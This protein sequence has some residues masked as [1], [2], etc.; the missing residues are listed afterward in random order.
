[1][2]VRDRGRVRLR[3]SRA[4]LCV[5]SGSSKS[6]KPIDEQLQVQPRRPAGFVDSQRFFQSLPCRIKLAVNRIKC[7]QIIGNQGPQSRVRSARTKLGIEPTCLV[8][9][10]VR[11]EMAGAAVRFGKPRRAHGGQGAARTAPRLRFST[12][13]RHG[14]YQLS[15]VCERTIEI[16]KPASGEQGRGIA[17]QRVAQGRDGQRG[18]VEFFRRDAVQACDQRLGRQ[19]GAIAKRS[20]DNQ[21]GEDRAASDSGPAPIGLKLG[22]NNPRPLDPQ[23]KDQKWPAPG[24]PACP[25]TSGD[26]SAPELRGDMKWSISVSEYL[27]ICREPG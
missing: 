18:A 1:M 15:G 20:A 6:R 17:F 2:S 4:C 21:L 10:P 25:V 12:T 14:D 3:P 19:S 9:L 5:T 11:G 26:S 8:M 16:E 13:L 22:R 24:A 27:P 7:G 23:I